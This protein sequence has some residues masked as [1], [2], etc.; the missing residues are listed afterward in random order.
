MPQQQQALPEQ[1]TAEGQ[2]VSPD[3]VGL[4]IPVENVQADDQHV[5]D[6]A[7]DL[8]SSHFE[9]DDP[10]NPDGKLMSLLMG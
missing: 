7:L 9:Y 3:N 2:S 5:E 4:G 8:P 1:F 6:G 10:A